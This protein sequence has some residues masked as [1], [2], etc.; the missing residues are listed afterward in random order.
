MWA[1][2]MVVST[3]LM[4]KCRNGCDNKDTFQC[5]WEKGGRPPRA[6]TTALFLPPGLQIAHVC[7]QIAGATCP[8]RET[9]GKQ[10]KELNDGKQQEKEL[11]CVAGAT[12][13]EL[14]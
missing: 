1:M 6:G 2:A 13:K 11:R 9:K 4:L 8:V 5:G 14:C 10:G 12:R 7:L 3:T